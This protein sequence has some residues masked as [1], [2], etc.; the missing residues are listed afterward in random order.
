M[1]GGCLC[2]C[3]KWFILVSNEFKHIK[4]NMFASLEKWPLPF[5]R[6][7]F[8]LPF[9]THYQVLSVQGSEWPSWSCTI[10]LWQPTGDISLGNWMGTKSV[11]CRTGQEPVISIISIS[12]HFK[13]VLVN[14]HSTSSRV[15]FSDNVQLAEV[16]TYFGW[17]KLN[18]VP[19]RRGVLR[20]W[21]GG[22]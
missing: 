17:S 12:T 20:S 7:L 18:W 16:F 14:L 6:S 8:L 11:G 15:G 3:P 9:L 22:A 4:D 1:G 19:S 2:E 21:R 5:R 10:Q 13:S